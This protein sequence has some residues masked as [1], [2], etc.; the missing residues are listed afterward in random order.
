MSVHL[1]FSLKIIVI[2]VLLNCPIISNFTVELRKLRRTV[3]CQN[4][5]TQRKT[6]ICLD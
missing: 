1:T 3:L 4:S 5:R 6:F 2:D